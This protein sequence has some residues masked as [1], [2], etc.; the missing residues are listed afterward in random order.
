MD[1]CYSQVIDGKTGQL[2]VIDHALIADPWGINSDGL[3]SV[4]YNGVEYEIRY[5]NADELHVPY[6]ALTVDGSQVAPSVFRTVSGHKIMT[7]EGW[8]VEHYENGQVIRIGYNQDSNQMI[9][10]MP[11]NFTINRVDYWVDYD[12]APGNVMSGG[13]FDGQVPCAHFRVH[14]PQAPNGAHYM[15]GKVGGQTARDQYH[16]VMRYLS[17]LVPDEA[18][19][20]CSGQPNYSCGI[21]LLGGPK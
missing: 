17:P 20:S 10:Y 8:Y 21:R 13:E 5:A 11:T 7:N 19:K 16:Q 18:D 12:V 6:T 1:D 9:Y 3:T 14:L 2:V 4:T 15:K